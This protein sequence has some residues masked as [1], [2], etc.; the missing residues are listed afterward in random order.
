M[1]TSAVNKKSAS[2]T[3]NRKPMASATG[4]PGENPALSPREDE[5][6][7]LLG[8]PGDASQREGKAIPY[9]L[10]IGTAVIAQA[11]I[12]ILAAIVWASV[13]TSKLMLFSAHPTA[14]ILYH[15]RLTSL[16]AG[17]VLA[18]QGALILQPTH[19]STQKRQG[20]NVHAVLNGVGLAALI[21]GL[22]V[23]EVNKI[24]HG[25]THFVSPHAILGLVTYI[26]L[27][28]QT[29]VGFTQYYTPSLY[30]GVNNAKK[31][32]KYHRASG[33]VVLTLA[34]ATVAAATQTD[35]N[36]T[37][38]HIRLWSVLVTTVLVLVG[39]VPRIK[40]QKFGF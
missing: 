24:G 29:L 19:T 38:L 13:F 3:R 21:A 28:V 20:T 2:S 37:T 9:N 26:F 31:L 6:E 32:Y 8:E 14:P 36:K 25:G 40:K 17:I 18:T 12:W 23:I 16:Q 5:Q 7:P 4:I 35:F 33:Y 10:V 15:V 1:K 39:V 22:V 34:L 30:G 27:V 11:G